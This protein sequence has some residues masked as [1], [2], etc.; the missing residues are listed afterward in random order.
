MTFRFVA[1]ALLAGGLAWRSAVEQ[2]GQDS[3]VGE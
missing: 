2:R 3:D 1:I